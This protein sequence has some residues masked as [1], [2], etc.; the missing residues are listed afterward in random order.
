MGYPLSKSRLETKYFG[1]TCSGGGF[2]NTDHMTGEE[3]Y[4]PAH[5]ETC[6]LTCDNGLYKVSGSAG[7]TITCENGMIA[8]NFQSSARVYYCQKIKYF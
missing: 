8:G 4:I 3:Y 7:S 2:W 1:M 6:E 5:L